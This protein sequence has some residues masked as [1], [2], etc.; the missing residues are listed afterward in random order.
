MWYFN[1]GYTHIGYGNAKVSGYYGIWFNKDMDEWSANMAIRFAVDTT[2]C[3]YMYLNLT[4][5]DNNNEGIRTPYVRL[6]NGGTTANPG[7]VIYDMAHPDNVITAM[8][9]G[10]TTIVEMSYHCEGNEGGNNPYQLLY[11]GANN[12]YFT[13]AP[14]P[15]VLSI[16]SYP[17][18]NISSDT[19]QPYEVTV[20]NGCYYLWAR[21]NPEAIA[22]G[23]AAGRVT[24][25]TQGFNRVRVLYQCQFYEPTTHAI[26]IN[27]Q[28]VGS[29]VWT[30]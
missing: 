25:P 23:N 15:H 16:P 8:A 5:L 2:N 28:G 22:Y 10:N 3:K 7:A 26:T 11:I 24:F 9:T 18:T 29:S 27:G 1:N 30:D 19:N 6:Y 4:R 12:L 14:M 17:M 13:S 20:N 21:R